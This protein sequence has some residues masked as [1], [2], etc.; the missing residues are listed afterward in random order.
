LTYPNDAVLANQLDVRVSD[1]SLAIPLPV[2]LEVAQVT[3]MADLVGGGAVRLLEGVDY[4]DVPSAPSKIGQHVSSLIFL[5]TSPS[6][7]R[8]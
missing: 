5:S 2:G 6:S 3:H 1:A 8:R 4:A 7:P